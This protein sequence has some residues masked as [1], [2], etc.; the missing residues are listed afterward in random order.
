MDPVPCDQFMQR[1]YFRQLFHRVCIRRLQV[2]LRIDC[3]CTRR[4]LLHDFG[5]WKKQMKARGV[6][7]EEEKG[8]TF[9]FFSF[10][11]TTQPRP[12]GLLLDDFQNGGSSPDDP[13]F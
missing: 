3:Y 5:T 10:L 9:S 4:S 13:P 2:V 6:D 8:V 7:W 1:A 11:L 12:Q